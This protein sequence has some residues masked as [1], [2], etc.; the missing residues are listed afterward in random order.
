MLPFMMCCPY[1]HQPATMTIISNPAQVCVEHALEFW[2]GLL[3]YAA[4]DHSDLCVGHERLCTC[5]SCATLKAPES[6]SHRNRDRRTVAAK[7]EAFLDSPRLVTPT[8]TR[9]GRSAAYR[10]QRAARIRDAG[11]AGHEHGLID[12]ESQSPRWAARS[13]ENGVIAWPGGDP[14]ADFA[15][16]PR[17]ASPDEAAVPCPP[18]SRLVLVP[19]RCLP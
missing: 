18:M 17:P 2:T 6:A 16:I 9:P 15:G 19:H 14:D 8:S 5:R 1:C 7:P 13:P 3:V 11:S 10:P 12:A 4:K